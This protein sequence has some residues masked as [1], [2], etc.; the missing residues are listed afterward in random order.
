M[1]TITWN[2]S[3]NAFTVAGNWMPQTLPTSGDTAVIT[4]GTVTATGLSLNSLTIMLNSSDSAS[5]TL[6]LSDTTIGASSQLNIQAGGTNA[7]L[8]TQ[9]T[10]NNAGVISATGA[11]PGAVSFQIDNA[12]DGSATNFLNTGSI[13]VSDVDL[14]IVTSGNNA[15][16][17]LENDGLISIRNQTQTPH[18]AYVS[19]HILG[20]GTILL[21]SAV[22]FEAA[23]AVGAGQTFIFERSVGS[24]STLR[25]DAGKLFEGTV[26]GF[27]SSDSIQLISGQWDAAA[28]AST[29][30]NDGVLTLS[31][32]GSV[33]K[34]IPFKGSYRLDSFKL[35]ESASTGSGQASTTIMTTVAEAGPVPTLGAHDIALTGSH[36]Q[37]AIAKT[38]DGQAQIRDM[39]VGR[40]GTQVIAG[41]Q[42]IYFA[43]GT[44]EFDPTNTQASV[45]RLYQAAF[46]RVPDLVGFDHNVDLVTSNV[47]PLSELAS[48][49]T[50]SP[51]FISRFSSLDNSDFVQQLYQ[52]VL[53]RAPEAAGNQAWLNYLDSGASRGDALRGFADSLENRKQILP[54]TGDKND[55]ETFRLYE[56]ALGRTPDDVGLANWSGKLA[57][58][59]TPEEVAKGFVG[60]A[61]FAQK[62]GALSPSDF[63]TQ[64]YANVLHRAPDA[65]GLQNFVTALNNG[66][67]QE[68]VLVSFSDSTENL[69]NTA[70]ATHDAWVF[71]G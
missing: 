62:Y 27:A 58:G 19:S 57:Q 69:I 31:L 59:S 38:S 40:D 33:V 55:A 10:V 17:Q 18:M 63:V 51:E 5:S 4:A 3:D 44:G 37:Y 53:H 61:E 35:Q 20:T 68:H 71:L 15:A 70:P 43:D 32:G 45:T 65:P 52:N 36:D 12:S 67:T 30:V 41:L 11:N 6:V 7:T 39:V 50:T 66:A 54:T 1:A 42:H 56:A 29:D 2:G 14:Q 26:A 48:S 60:S 8:R 64:L 13:Q 25:I 9:G 28:Y 21:G 24:A 22:T 34:S 23:G 46:D 47:V 16:N 49:F